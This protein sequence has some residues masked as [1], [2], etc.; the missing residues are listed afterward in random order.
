MVPNDRIVLFVTEPL[1]ALCTVG[2]VVPVVG[3]L[4][5]LKDLEIRLNVYNFR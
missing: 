2:R 4:A 5:T 3:L 1:A